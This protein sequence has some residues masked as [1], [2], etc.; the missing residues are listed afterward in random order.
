[1][2]KSNAIW[3]IDIG[4]CALK[5]LRCV[6]GDEPGKITADAFDFIEYPKILS[7]PEADPVEL[8]RDAIAQFL[9]RNQV[10]EDRVAISV[11][12]QSGLA[13]FIKLPP[14]DTKKIPDIVR[15]EARQ[16]IPFA[17]E[18]VVFDWQQM[19]GGTE[20]DGF[21]LET[22]VGLFAMKREQVFRALRPFTDANVEVDII[23]LT[24]LAL[25]NFVVFDQM[26]DL[27]AVEDF[28]AKDPPPST[29]VVSLGTDTTDLVVT[30]GYRVWQR[31]IPLGGNHFTKALTKELKLTFAKAEHLKRNALKAEDP[32]AVFLAMRP[33]FNDLVTEVQRSISFFQSVDRTAKIGRVIPLGNAMKL[34]GLQKY[35]GQSLGYEVVELKEYRGLAGAGV[36]ATPAF[37][38]NLLSF[39][40]CYGLALQGLKQAQL[41]TNLIPPEIIKDRLIRAKKPWAVATVAALLLGCTAGFFGVWRSYNSVRADQAMKEAMDRAESETKRANELKSGYDDATTQ[42]NSVKE[43]ANRLN[44]INERRLLWPEVLKAIGDC[45]PQDPPDFK[46]VA[47]NPQNKKIEDLLAELAVKVHS[48][49]RIYIDSLECQHESNLHDWFAGVQ[50]K[51]TAQQS[52]VSAAVEKSA[53]APAPDNTGQSPNST[54][55]TS[56]SIGPSGEGW[57][58]EIVGHHYHNQSSPIGAK[59]VVETLIKNLETKEI[60]LPSFNGKPPGKVL[61]KDLG[62]G[63]PVLLTGGNP[64]PDEIPLPGYG[65]E[66]GNPRRGSGDE[67]QPIVKAFRFDFTVDLCWKET[68]LS[69]RLETAK[70]PTT[71]KPATASAGPGQ[72]N[73]L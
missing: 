41:A 35:L 27:P 23:Q 11:P 5:A 33:V 69:A 24:P 1:M 4:Q 8:V 26:Q 47:D 25:Y 68:P 71:D 58:I 70:P 64:E 55:A 59:Y 30:N 60:S 62:I 44:S 15:Y 2:A 66:G 49:K 6:P 31:N 29:I 10:T 12:G 56:S 39:G 43:I 52:E 72:R 65:G 16:Q 21:S 28:D 20:E 14:V 50:P 7:Q 54:D 32:K 40:V 3:G 67:G 48:S 13:R 73:P 63:Y 18:D 42:F 36:V 53:T 17:L 61:I 9:S 34:R 51:W 22:E 57:I 38:D 46:L 37:K 45:V 19:A